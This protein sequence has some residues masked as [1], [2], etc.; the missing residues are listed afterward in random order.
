M[1]ATSKPYPA[2]HTQHSTSPFDDG[3][4]LDANCHHRWVCRRKT[5][6]SAKLVE[7]EESFWHVIM[8]FIH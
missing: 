3:G 2:I 1:D 5:N 8:W 7:E 4:N 6:L